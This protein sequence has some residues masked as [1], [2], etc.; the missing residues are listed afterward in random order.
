MTRT[1]HS[2]SIEI[3]RHDT[4][5]ALPIHQQEVIQ[6]QETVVRSS[7]EVDAEKLVGQKLDAKYRNKQG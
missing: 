7:M 1:S 2:E 6:S 3:N 4:P 5:P